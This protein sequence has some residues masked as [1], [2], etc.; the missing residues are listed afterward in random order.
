MDQMEVSP[1]A[2]E[3]SDIEDKEERVVPFLGS[4]PAVV[5]V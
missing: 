2:P 5:L 3:A 4:D 1:D